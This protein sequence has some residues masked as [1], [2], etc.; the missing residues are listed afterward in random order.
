MKEILTGRKKAADF[1]DDHLDFTKISKL[2]LRS[3]TVWNY[4]YYPI[5]FTTEEAL[6]QAQKVLNDAKIFP[7]RY[8]Y[9]SLNTVNYVNPAEMPVSESIS[10]RV[11]CLPLYYDL[12]A[13][14]LAVIVNLIS[15]G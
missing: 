9:P 4:S 14:E 5:V 6:V 7:R 13:E 2:K 11:L 3:S 1:Y 12:K 10:T 15:I 8:F